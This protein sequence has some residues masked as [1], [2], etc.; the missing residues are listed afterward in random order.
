MML[1][2][3]FS[4]VRLLIESSAVIICHC[5]AVTDR[6]IR[7]CALEGACSLDAIGECTGAGTNCGG[8]HSAIEEIVRDCTREGPGEVAV[9]RLPLVLE[10]SRAA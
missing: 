4:Y 1:K 6:A 10:P 2:V 9:R 8:C 7:A 3:V 5:H